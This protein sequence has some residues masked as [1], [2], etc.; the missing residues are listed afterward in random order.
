MK[1]KSVLKR[2]A[3]KRSGRRNLS[4]IWRATYLLGSYSLKFS[5]LLAGVAFI[6]LLFLSIYQYLLT[7]PH[8]KLERVIVKGG[9]ED[10]KRVLL[11]MSRLRPETSLLAI[12]MDELKRRMERHPWIRSV[13]LEKRFPHTLIIHA[14]KEKPY[15]VVLTDRLHYMNRWGRIFEKVDPTGEIDYPIITGISMTGSEREIQLKLAADVLK[16]LEAEKGP[17]SLKELSEVHVK[18]R[19]IVS[20]Y[21]RSL[22]AIVEIHGSQLDIKMDELK[23]LVVHLNRTGHIH[24]VR[25]IN[26]NYKEGVV[27]SFKGGKVSKAPKV[28]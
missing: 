10:L 21:F 16:V 22:P 6:S 11:K 26:L 9:D 8:I 12:N 5:C 18:K 4:N 2:Q 19:G 20:L 27:V 1:S 25:A 3:V 23:R 15:A 7:S 13:S 14:E 28:G 24:R 17:W